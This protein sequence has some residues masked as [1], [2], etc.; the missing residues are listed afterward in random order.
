MI[1]TCKICQKEV[2]ECPSRAR[3]YCSRTCQALGQ[4]GSGNHMFHN[5]KKYQR[6]YVIVL[7]GPRKYMREHRLVMEQHLRRKLDRNEHVHHVN[8]IKDDNRIE[9][10]MIV[11]TSEHSKLHR[12]M[13]GIRPINRFVRAKMAAAK[14]SE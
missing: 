9:N 5:G 10:L 7:I 3:T 1:Y 13:D 11:S 2:E 14:G 8:G 6:G 4:T 12:R